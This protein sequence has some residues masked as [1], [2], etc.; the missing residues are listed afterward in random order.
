[1]YFMALL[2]PLYTMMPMSVLSHYISLIN[3]I[4][5]PLNVVLKLREYHT[6]Y[7]LSRNGFSRFLDYLIFY[8]T[9]TVLVLFLTD[10][11]LQLQRL[12]VLLFF[13]KL[14]GLL[15]VILLQL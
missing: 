7:F 4:I 5:M 12:Q 11:G 15:V 2:S 10:L 1:M 13:L 14:A 3:F 8:H 9:N 6:V